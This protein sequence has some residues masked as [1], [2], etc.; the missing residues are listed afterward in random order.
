MAA[1][2]GLN[3]NCLLIV[4]RHALD[5]RTGIRRRKATNP[6][7]RSPLRDRVGVSLI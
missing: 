3:E 4:G 6:F 2:D 1:V 5:P 7:R